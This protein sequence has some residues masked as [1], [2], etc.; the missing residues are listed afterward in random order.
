MKRIT[1]LVFVT[2]SYA[3][4]L[5]AQESISFTIPKN[6]DVVMDLVYAFSH[7]LK[8]DGI[9]D[10]YM[11]DKIQGT[12]FS[13]INP[14]Q[15]DRSLDQY[16][17]VKNTKSKEYLVQAT[18][19]IEALDLDDQHAQIKIKLE[20]ALNNANKERNSS[21][22]KSTGQ[23]EKELEAF[24][25]SDVT[26]IKDSYDVG[27]STATADFDAS[28][29]DSDYTMEEPPVKKT[30]ANLSKLIKNGQTI[31]LPL[32]AEYFTKKL[33][34][35]PTTHEF[36]TAVG[37]KYYSWNLDES[38]GLLYV[39]MKNGLEYY[40]FYTLDDSVITGLPFN[41]EMNYSSLEWCLQEFKGYLPQWVQ[42][43]G[44]NDDTFLQIEFSTKDQFI[45]LEF[46]SE[47]KN[48]KTVLIANKPLN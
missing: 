45:H 41:L 19:N 31:P 42:V 30:S 22:I 40:S 3:S 17:L 47:T 39:K 14:R 48:L 13:L 1:V 12:Y 7:D 44:E 8:Q 5:F 36:E 29:I 32:S 26:I 46:F 34:L 15:G 2:L 33:K 23:F 11:G 6:S 35:T 16:A 28:Y 21:Q 20:S 9:T 38:I 43:V 37:E 24:L 18:W 27:D 4:S 25:N 10:G